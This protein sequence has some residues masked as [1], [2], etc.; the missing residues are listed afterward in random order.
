MLLQSVPPYDA[1]YYAH[2]CGP[3]PYERSPHW[4][5]FFSGIAAELVRSLRPKR[6]FDAGC[7]WGFLVEAFWDLGVEAHG[8]DISAYAISNVRRDMQPFCRVGS[9]T[10]PIRVVYDL[11]TC[12]EVL[13]HMPAEEAQ[14]AVRHMT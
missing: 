8:V 2:G 13:E 7:A 12:I 5:N 1:E 11:V 4:L 14:E 9:L 3:I 6:V 10:E